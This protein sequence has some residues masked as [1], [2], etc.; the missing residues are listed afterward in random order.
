MIKDII[1]NSLYGEIL[2]IFIIFAYIF[3]RIIQRRMQKVMGWN[4]FE[5]WVYRGLE[6]FYK[7]NNYPYPNDKAKKVTKLIIKSKNRECNLK[8][9]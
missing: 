3:M 9:N 4:N 8:N 6:D 5:F 7:F 2:V 1:Y